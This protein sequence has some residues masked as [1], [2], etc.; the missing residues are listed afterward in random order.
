M[1]KEKNEFND[2]LSIIASKAIKNSP[3]EAKLI[4]N[5]IIKYRGQNL[6]LQ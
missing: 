1:D 4:D 2:L 5:F 6:P 3:E